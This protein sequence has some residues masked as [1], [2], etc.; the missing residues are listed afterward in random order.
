M[1]SQRKCIRI[2]GLEGIAAYCDHPVLRRL[3]GS[4][5]IGGPG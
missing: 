1:G 4:P 2:L 5:G 3:T